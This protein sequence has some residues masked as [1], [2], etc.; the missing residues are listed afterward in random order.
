MYRND[1]GYSDPTAGMALS[2]VMS[3]VMLSVNED[4]ETL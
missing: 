4:T 1:K 2:N 3:A